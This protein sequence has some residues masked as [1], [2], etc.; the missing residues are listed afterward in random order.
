MLL[1]IADGAPFVTQA[2]TNTPPMTIA[3]SDP[4][5]IL[6]LF[7]VIAVIVAAISCLPNK[8]YKC[9]ECGFWSYSR[10]EAAG[11][12]HLASLHKIDL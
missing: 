1:I 7:I 4:M 11:H 9:K 8:R 12:V 5:A 6:A 3:G 10:V 2:V